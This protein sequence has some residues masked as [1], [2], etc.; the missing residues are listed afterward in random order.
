MISPH[1]REVIPMGGTLT[2]HVSLSPFRKVMCFC[3]WRLPSVTIVVLMTSVYNL[4]FWV[5][6]LQNKVVQ[7]NVVGEWQLRSSITSCSRDDGNRNEEFEAH[8]IICQLPSAAING[9]Q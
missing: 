7:E 5:F 2:D 3:S 6:L 4:G 9:H 8:A 1:Y